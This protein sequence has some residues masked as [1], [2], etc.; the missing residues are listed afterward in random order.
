VIPDSEAGLLALEVAPRTPAQRLLARAEEWIYDL[1]AREHWIFRVYDAGNAAWAR[2]AFRGVRRR[3]GEF[4]AHARTKAG[5][6]AVMRVVRPGQADELAALFADFQFRYRPPHPLDPGAVR[7]LLA[8]PHC[9]PFGIWVQG[10]LMGYSLIRLF[11]PRRAVMGIWFLQSHATRGHGQIFSYAT[12]RWT[13]SEGLPNFITVPRDNVASLRG[14][15]L[16]GFRILRTNR[17]FHVL[18]H[19]GQSVPPPGATIECRFAGGKVER[20]ASDA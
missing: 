17:R 11:F 4:E 2:V 3:A 14:A 12:S 16:S 18:L 13:R 1:N 5:V 19:N 9:I 7:R 15:M 20:E 6:D 10:R 8:A